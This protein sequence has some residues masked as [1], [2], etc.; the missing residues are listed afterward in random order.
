MHVCELISCNI[1]S[2]CHGRGGC[3]L[4]HSGCLSPQSAG[5]NR[6]QLVIC[7]RDVD[8]KSYALNNMVIISPH[9]RLRE[10]HYSRH[11]P[12]VNAPGSPDT[13]AHIYLIYFKRSLLL[14]GL[15]CDPPA[16]RG[17]DEKLTRE[18]FKWAALIHAGMRLRARDVSSLYLSVISFSGQKEIRLGSGFS[19]FA[20]GLKGLRFKGDGVRGGGRGGRR[21]GGGQP[22]C[23]FVACV[24]CMR[25]R[26]CS[27]PPFPQF[28]WEGT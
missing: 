7:P 4:L 12:A 14:Q 11:H 9:A 13:A 8:G 6:A 22:V 24:C 10:G 21:R 26:L 28:A 3:G 18:V 25:W 16:R 23:V 1:M 2:Y 19:V 15:L 17:P 20:W 5:N 27:C